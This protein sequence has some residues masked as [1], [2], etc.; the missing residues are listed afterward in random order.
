MAKTGKRYNYIFQY[1]K[2]KGISIDQNEF[3]F[4]LESHPDWGTLLAVNDTLD[5]FNINTAVFKVNNDNIKD[6]PSRFIAYI[7]EE[8]KKP[9]FAY[10]VKDSS[11]YTI[12]TATNNYGSSVPYEEFERIFKNI[13]LIAENSKELIHNK[14]S[15]KFINNNILFGLLMLIIIGIILF[16]S[17]SALMVTLTCISIVGLILSIEALK[18]E[19]GENS[20]VSNALCSAIPNADCSQVINSKKTS[21]LI[22]VKISDISICFFSSQLLSLLLFSLLSDYSHY[23][24]FL[25]ISLILAFPLT[26]YSL[27]F[28]YKIEKKWCPIC[29]SIILLIYIQFLLLISNDYPFLKYSISLPL[30]LLFLFGLAFTALVWSFFKPIIL[31]LSNLKKES[32]KLRRLVRN[33]DLFKSYLKSQNKIEIPNHTPI[34]LG[35][36]KANFIISVVTS[37]Y[38]GHCAQ[39]DVILGNILKKHYNDIRIN[40]FFPTIDWINLRDNAK[41]LIRYLFDSYYNEGEESFINNLSYIFATKDFSMYENKSIENIEKIEKKIILQS[42][43]CISNNLSLTPTIFLNGY[44]YPRIYDRKYLESFIL[45][46]IEDQDL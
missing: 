29:L 15:N 22:K 11:H 34:V 23:F 38:C 12:Y 19:L 33:Y 25:C 17:K 8:Q 2:S 6:L 43:F 28:Q 13:V 16:F 30:L 41:N 24:N 10:V 7:N 3:I 44:K 14:P 20:L 1:L 37:P 36:P 5:F 39:M 46:L 18:T 21:K 31:H 26:L 4:Q 32:L 9:D 35:N 40:I 42:Q 27:Y 45:E